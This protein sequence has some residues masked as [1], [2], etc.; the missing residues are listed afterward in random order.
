[1]LSPCLSILVQMW[2]DSRLTWSPEQLGDVKSFRV[3]ANRIWK[4]DIRLYNAYV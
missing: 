4:P 2:T 1:M 3:S